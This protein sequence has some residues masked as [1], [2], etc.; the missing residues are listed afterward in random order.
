MENMH[1]DAFKLGYLFCFR[2]GEKIGGEKGDKECSAVGCPGTDLTDINTYF[3]EYV[4]EDSNAND[5]FNIYVAG[6]SLAP[7]PPAMSL[8]YNMT[9]SSG[10]TNKTLG[11]ADKDK[12]AAVTTVWYS[13]E[14]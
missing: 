9:N 13:N 6:F 7:M 5:Y 10:M 1:N 14:V 2:P 8:S 4:L 12:E 11:G 3:S